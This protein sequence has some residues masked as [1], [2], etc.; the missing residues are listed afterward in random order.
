VEL[1]A[2]K[3]NVDSIM[4]KSGSIFANPATGTITLT[5]TTD[6]V[7]AAD[8]II[9]NGVRSLSRMVRLRLQTIKVTSK[10]SGE[11]GFDVSAAVS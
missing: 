11:A 1:N 4:T 3:D 9:A 5:D 2:M 6:V 10:D 8:A 7:E